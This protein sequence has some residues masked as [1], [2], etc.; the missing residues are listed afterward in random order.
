[1]KKLLSIF[2]SLVLVSLLFTL[3]FMAGLL[4]YKLLFG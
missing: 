3:C 4:I 2:V 1:M